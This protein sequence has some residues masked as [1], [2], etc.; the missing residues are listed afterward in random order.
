MKRYIDVG[1]KLEM[2]EETTI[3]TTDATE[4]EIPGDEAL[5]QIKRHTELKI[6]WYNFKKNRNAVIGLIITIF[7]L[8]IAIFADVISPYSPIDQ[9]QN[10]L[11]SPSTEHIFGTDALGR[12]M[13][14]R[15]IH[16]SRISIGV[17]FGA[18]GISLVI[19]LTLGI[20]GGYFGGNV[21]AIVTMVIDMFMSFPGLLLAMVIASLLGPTLPNVM[22]AVGIG[23]FTLFARLVRSS[24]YLEKEK[25]YIL[26]ARS[27]GSSN[28]LI[29]FRHIIPNIFS[30][31]IIITTVNI[32]SAILMT[33]SL[34]FLGL[35]AQPPLAEWGN[36]VN[37]GRGYIQIAPWLIWFPGIA[38]I[39]SV[40]GANL[41]GDGLRDALD[42]KLRK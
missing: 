28:L 40:L 42:P 27:V 1:E 20:A 23:Q 24:V 22:I 2:K 10:L 37:I 41:L 15:V 29:I 34:G 5:D 31:V 18:V 4:F 11:T 8:S 7:L 33:A 25:E 17:G 13:L 36:M 19:G 16:G 26:A 32:G 3:Q 38:I 21:D 9:T 14:S 6:M 30:T 39:L 12:D 35:G